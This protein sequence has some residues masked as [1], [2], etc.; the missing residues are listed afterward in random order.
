[1]DGYLQYLIV[2][3]SSKRTCKYGRFE[4]QNNQECD[5]FSFNVQDDEYPAAMFGENDSEGI[6]RLGCL[7]QKDIII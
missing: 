4:L 7:I 5:N 3:S 1:M 2:T 6:K